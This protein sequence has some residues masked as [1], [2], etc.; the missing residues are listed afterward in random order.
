[1][2]RAEIVTPQNASRTL[3]EPPVSAPSAMFASPHA[4]DTAEL[5]CSSATT[6]GPV[7]IATAGNATAFV[8]KV[9]LQ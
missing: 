6:G 3:T 2:G 8:N 7:G 1:M 5:R 4:T 9:V